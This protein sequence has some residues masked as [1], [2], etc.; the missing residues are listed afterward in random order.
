MDC[1]LTGDEKSMHRAS[2][3]VRNVLFG[4]GDPNFASGTVWTFAIMPMNSGCVDLIYRPA[5]Q[6]QSTM[7]HP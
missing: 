5:V 3:K 2:Q 1:D 6:L 7:R 4:H